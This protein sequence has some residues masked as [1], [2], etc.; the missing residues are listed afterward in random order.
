MEIGVGRLQGTVERG[1]KKADNELDVCQE[2]LNRGI[3]VCY[4]KDCPHKIAWSI[5][6]CS[7]FCP[8]LVDII[9]N[10]FEYAHV[11]TWGRI[12]LPTQD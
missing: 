7:N 8:T 2:I 12:N 9:F 10:P 3:V 6:N 4:L 11:H 1:S 5:T